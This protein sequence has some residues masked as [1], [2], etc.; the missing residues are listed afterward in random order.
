MGLIPTWGS[1]IFS[2]V[3]S[4]RK[5][6]ANRRG[7]AFEMKQISSYVGHFQKP[8]FLFMALGQYRTSQITTAHR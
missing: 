7:P 1:E 3:P 2:V 5:K 6:K 4:D 8:K